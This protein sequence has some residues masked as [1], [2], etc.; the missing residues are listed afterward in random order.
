MKQLLI[1]NKGLLEV[2]ALTLLGASSKRGDGSKIGMF[3]SGNKYA[4]AYF[5]RNGHSIKII[6]GG[7]EIKIGLAK[8]TLRGKEFDVLCINDAPTSIT[9]EFGHKWQLWEAIRELYSNAV[10]EGLLHFGLVDAVPECPADATQIIISGSNELETILFNIQDYICTGKEVLFANDNGQILR[11]HGS[12]GR[13]YY[14]GILVYEHDKG[15]VFD[16]NVNSISLNESRQPVCSWQIPENIW[17]LVYACDKPQICR[18]VLDGLSKDKLLLE[19][20]LD[21]SFVDNQSS[22]MNKAAWNEALE[23]HKIAPWLLGG[24]VKD[25]DRPFTWMLPTKLFDALLE[26]CSAAVAATGFI[27]NTG[28]AMFVNITPNALQQATLEKTIAFLTE[29]K[30]L[31]AIHIRVAQFITKDILG[32][33]KDGEIILADTCLD[34]G[35]HQTAVC[36]LE[37][38]LHIQSGFSDMTRAFQNSIFEAWLNY[39]KSVNAYVI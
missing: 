23:G 11:K 37:E 7:V 34:G 1:T 19:N 38:A 32:T 6:T 15:S 3:G 13:L 21:D 17:K 30:L 26:Y 35:V 4:L 28:R 9:T 14:K 2:A 10:D 25:D 18:M 31:P 8:Q 24:Y 33:I 12:A 16:Y 29:V 22:H 36:I 20:K 27:M 5:A 39:A